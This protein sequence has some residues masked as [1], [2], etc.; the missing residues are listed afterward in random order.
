MNDSPKELFN[1]KILVT[2]FLL[3]VLLVISAQHSFLLFHTLAEFFAI[4]AAVVAWQTHTFTRNYFLMYLGC[5]YIWIAALDI[6]HALSYSGMNIFEAIT[7]DR[8]TAINFWI[9]ARYLEAFILLSAPWFI[10]HKFNRI[11]AVSIYGL[12]CISWCA[13]GCLSSLVH[14]R[15]PSHKSNT[16]H[17]RPGLWPGP[18]AC[19]LLLASTYY[20]SWVLARVLSS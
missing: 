7:V 19:A 4:I 3:S 8:D 6:M 11:Y 1:T 16:S 20:Y 2:P 18:A 15:V 17:Q 5:G 14:L 9:S 13:R 12:V 10:T